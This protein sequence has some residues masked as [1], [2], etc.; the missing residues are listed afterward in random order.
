MV[1][2]VVLGPGH[3]GGGGVGDGE[4]E[5]GEFSGGSSRSGQVASFEFSGQNSRILLYR[6]HCRWLDSPGGGRTGGS[7]A[8]RGDH[9]LSFRMHRFVSVDPAL[10][11]MKM[12]PG[13]AESKR[14]W[15]SLEIPLTLVQKAL[16]YSCQS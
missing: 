13:E 12:H 6:Y 5:G 16:K 2:V 3:G 9:E 7:S 15:W 8:A 4:R 11:F 1:V 10:S 14:I